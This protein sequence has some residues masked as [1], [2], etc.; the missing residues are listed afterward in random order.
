MDQVTLLERIAVGFL[1]ALVGG[2]IVVDVGRVIWWLAK[3]LT[4]AAKELKRG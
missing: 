3:G 4:R 1:L 2:W